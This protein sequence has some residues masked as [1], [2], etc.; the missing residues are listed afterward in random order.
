MTANPL[1]SVPN[2]ISPKLLPISPEEMNGK[3]PSEEALLAS[4]VT[5]LVMV[6]EEEEEV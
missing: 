4:A 3:Q 6:S 5:L 1:Q 2:P